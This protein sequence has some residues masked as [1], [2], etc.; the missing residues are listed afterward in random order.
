L[1]TSTGP[2]L[3]VDGRNAVYRALYANR[4][5]E[6]HDFVVILRAMAAWI[7]LLKPSEFHIFWD[8]QREEIWR[9]KISETYKTRTD[10]DV[11]GVRERLG[12]VT[13]VARKILKVMGVRQYRRKAME[14]DDLIFAASRVLCPKDTIIVSSDTDYAQVSFYMPHVRLYDPGKK[15]FIERPAVNPVIAKALAG[16][17]TDTVNGY[18]GIGP[19][20]S[21]RLA[22][23]ITARQQFLDDYGIDMFG[24]N[25]LLV[26]LSLCPELLLNELYVTR[27]MATEVIYD[28]R[29]IHR[30]AHESKVLGLVSEYDQIAVPFK[31]LTQHGQEQ[32][33]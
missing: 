10:V 8:V 2:I 5:G 3:L 4:H 11:E 21:G 6:V 16:D 33:A 31:K 25:L 30:L 32:T 7:R 20:K 27:T 24:L 28:K 23:S 1:A 9:R 26:D 12:P 19:V 13:A 15:R 14:A 22:E 29:E 18:S 17:G